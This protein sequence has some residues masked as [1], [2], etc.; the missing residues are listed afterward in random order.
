MFRSV[1][2]RKAVDSTVINICVLAVGGTWPCGF[3][4]EKKPPPRREILVLKHS[5]YDRTG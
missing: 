4:M 5:K 1:A 2:L 3:T